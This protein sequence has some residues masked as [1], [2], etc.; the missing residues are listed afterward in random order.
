MKK[1]LFMLVFVTSG[2]HVNAQLLDGYNCLYL[3]SHGDGRHTNNEQLIVNCFRDKGFQII[4]N[5][6]LLP[7]NRRDRMAVLKCEYDFYIK[8]Q[9]GTFLTLELK[10]M[11]GENV[12]TLKGH[13]NSFASVKNEIV[14]ATRGALVTIKN[15][16][17][18]FDP[19]KTPHTQM[20]ESEISHWSEER[21]TS[22]LTSQTIDEIEGIYRNIGGSH[23]KLAIIKDGGNYTAVILETDQPNWAKTDVKAQFESIRDNFYTVK[24]YDDSC[25]KIETMAEINDKGILKIDDSSF[26]KIYP[27]GSK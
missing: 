18:T 5:E 3:V 17:Y 1:I 23:Y 27:L 15:Y 2:I 6:D 8:Y 25:N 13:G 11:L 9:V 26:M 12:M 4:E 10:N 24:F 7:Q 19:S 21:I 20:L 14:R 16:P 22:Y